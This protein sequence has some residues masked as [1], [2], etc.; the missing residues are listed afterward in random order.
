MNLAQILMGKEAEK[1]DGIAD[2]V[3]RDARADCVC[4]ANRKPCVYH[5]GFA[6]GI[7]VFLVTLARIAS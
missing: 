6:D 4:A 3:V 2:K 5:N 7:D 1:L